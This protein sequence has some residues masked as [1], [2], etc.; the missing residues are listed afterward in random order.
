M[1]SIFTFES[2][3]PGVSSPWPIPPKELANN[4]PEKGR[5]LFAGMSMPPAELAAN[6]G[7]SKLQAEPQEGPTEYKLHLL[8][9]P[10]R[11][12]T[13]TSTVQNVSGSYLSKSRK[14]RSQSETDLKPPL[15]TP[16]LAPSSQTRQNRLQHLTTQLL[17]R[18]QQSSPYHSSS[19]SSL[20]LPVLPE[21]DVELSAAKGPGP[22]IPGLEESSGALYEIGVSDDG[23][24]VGLA[25]DE[26]EESLTVLRAMAFSL[27]CD[28][29]ILRMII[30][31]DCQWTEETLSRMKAVNRQRKEKLWVAEMLVAP[32]TGSSKRSLEPPT[33]SL[34]DPDPN[35]GNSE[36][37]KKRGY[38]THSQSEQLRV[39]LTGSTT[40]GKSSLLGTL[41]TS[42]L[43]N[44][45]GKSR[46][47]LLKHRHEI[48]SGVTSSLAQE[49]F[50]YQDALPTLRTDVVNYA[51]GNVSSWNDIHSV[52]EPGRL[53]FVTDSAGHPRYRRTTVRGLVSWAPHWTL[54][55]VAADDEDDSSG[56]IG[57]TATSSEILGSAG[58]GV[59]LSKAHLELCL[60]LN[61]PLVIVITK[62]DIATKAGLRN[63][64]TKVLTTLKS[65]GRKPAILSTSSDERGEAQLQ[66]ISRDDAE[67][68]RR[69]IASVQP[70]EVHLL[71]PI[72]FTSAVTGSGI[73]GLH[74]VLRQL[75]VAFDY[76]LD[77]MTLVLQDDVPNPRSLFH[78]DEVF[79]MPTNPHHGNAGA[80]TS[81]T[82]LSG[83][84][85]YGKL[86]IGEKVIIGPCTH[87]TTIEARNS[88]EMHRASSFPGLIKG[89]PRAVALSYDRRRPL[90][91]DFAATTNDTRQASN[92]AQ[93]WQEVSITSLRNLRLPVRK[94]LAGQVGTVGIA[95]QDAAALASNGN[96]N[97]LE[98]RRGMVMIPALGDPTTRLPPAFNRFGAVFNQAGLPAWPGVIVTVYIASI[99]ASAK[100]VEVKALEGETTADEIFEFDRTTSK[101]SGFAIPESPASNDRTEILF[102]FAT[103]QEWVELGTPVLVTP[104][105]GP[106]LTGQ[107]EQ[108]ETGSAGLDGYVGTITHATVSHNA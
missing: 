5:P 10:R 41:S 53:V 18:L 79:V 29:Q 9:R 101:Q 58:E 4:N 78:I 88:P 87:D 40:S 94:L 37:D 90:S 104:G 56:K 25:R 72:V 35:G 55:C 45:R 85:R 22:L 26:L 68:A 100:I 102:E 97:S 63:T 82:I 36:V 33:S 39:S 81:S 49:L 59:D 47:S 92:H 108:R 70:N 1:A 23:I 74:A 86:E 96:T 13:A 34:D 77:V 31:G 84:I 19:K 3:P 98:I 95:F 76:S 54:C 67:A 61:L 32:H 14:P 64:L 60:K 28:V 16:V 2:E 42:T 93:T 91:G 52:I 48:V 43:D 69:T 73:G 11:S 65:A 75:P 103:S 99:R 15:P 66:T 83:Y 38:E 21:T 80:T 24:F 51:S 50:G 17:W 20:V 8:L 46:L 27:G 6:A 30:V 89:S 105:G 12:F 71:V 44:G 7:I 106:S 57:A 62:L 107:P